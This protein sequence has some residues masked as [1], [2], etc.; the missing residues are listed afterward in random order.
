MSSIFIYRLFAAGI[1]M[2]CDVPMNLKES[3]E[4]KKTGNGK[5]D[6][7]EWRNSLRRSSLA[8]STRPPFNFPSIKDR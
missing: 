3:Q 6:D 4:K 1:L 2:R 7:E 8:S 5:E